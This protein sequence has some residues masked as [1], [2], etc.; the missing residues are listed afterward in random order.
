M[1]NGRVLSGRSAQLRH[2]CGQ[3]H[4]YRPGLWRGR[5]VQI[6]LRGGPR[7]ARTHQLQQSARR[8]CFR[9][10]SPGP[11][12]DEGWHLTLS[13]GCD[14]HRNRHS[15]GRREEGSRTTQAARYSLPGRCA[16]V[17]SL[18][19]IAYTTRNLATLVGRDARDGGRIRRMPLDLTAAELETAARACRATA[20]QEGERAKQME[21]PT[22]CGPI[23]NAAQRYAA[24]AEK[25]EAAR[26]RA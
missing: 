8:T 6:R 16:I 24:L 10:V 3:S 19:A 22:T 26:K 15:R 17:G 2:N 9:S 1:I 23:E 7:R 13:G 12:D 18:G 20:Y 5:A 21:N 4:G 25:F 14:S 11:F